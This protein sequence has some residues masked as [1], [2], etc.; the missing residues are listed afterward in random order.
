MCTIYMGTGG[1]E[2]KYGIYVQM[3]INTVLLCTKM[4]RMLF[5]VGKI[6]FWAF[7][8][9]TCYISKSPV[10]IYMHEVLVNA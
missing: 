7:L 5:F 9:I 3:Y 6:S 10:P 4:P 8:Y 1:F 2:I